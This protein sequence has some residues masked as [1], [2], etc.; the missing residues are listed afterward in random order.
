MEG[1][2][3]PFGRSVSNPTDHPRRNFN[4]S[5]ATNKL[6]PGMLGASYS[7]F[8]VQWAE[9]VPWEGRSP[10]SHES[11]GGVKACGCCCR[12]VPNPV[13]CMECGSAGASPS[14][15]A[16]CQEVNAIGRQPSAGNC[17]AAVLSTIAAFS[18]S[19]PPELPWLRSGCCVGQTHKDLILPYLHPLN[20]RSRLRIVRGGIPRA[21]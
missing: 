11:S 15:T 20:F 10:V 2:P 12:A 16:P 1:P 4:L 9:R 14:R 21:R 6:D 18:L 17:T 13:S 8:Q 5:T 3:A 7:G 19:L